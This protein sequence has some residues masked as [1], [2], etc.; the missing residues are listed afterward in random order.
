MGVTTVQSH[1]HLEHTVATGRHAR[2][3]PVATV[4]CR[5]VVFNTRCLVRVSRSCRVPCSYDEMVSI[6]DKRMMTGRAQPVAQRGTEGGGVWRI[7]WHPHD[8]RLFVIA[9]MHRGFF[10]M[11]WAEGGGT[12]LA[13]EPQ[14][15]I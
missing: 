12:S 13:R 11:R 2:V 9:A 5:I 14:Q 4:V 7:K 3:C 10:V 15:R 1:P 8:P 6:W